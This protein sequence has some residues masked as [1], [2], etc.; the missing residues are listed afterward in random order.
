MGSSERRMSDEAFERYVFHADI[1]SEAAYERLKTEARRARAAEETLRA[2][3]DDVIEQRD[4]MIDE[5]KAANDG[6]FKLAADRDSLARERDEAREKYVKASEE[7]GFQYAEAHSLAAKFREAVEALDAV[8]EHD[9]D[10]GEPCWCGLPDF[11]RGERHDASCLL[12]RATL[13]RLREGSGE[14][15]LGV[16]EEDKANSDKFDGD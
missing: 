6:A 13:S 4:R 5:F 7:A 10:T 9:P 12:A 3:R 14:K 8:A 16:M 1:G 15:P 11:E 2:E